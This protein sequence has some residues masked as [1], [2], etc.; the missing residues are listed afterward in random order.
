MV[1]IPR[2]ASLAKFQDSM[3]AV[4]TG[5]WSSKVLC[6][7]SARQHRAC[8]A[9]RERIQRATRRPIGPHS[10]RV[11]TKSARQHRAEHP[12]K[13]KPGTLSS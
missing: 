12:K 13:Q 1:D 10:V 5:R 6:Q 4:T 7:L 9:F 8:S 3:G 11:G 2:P